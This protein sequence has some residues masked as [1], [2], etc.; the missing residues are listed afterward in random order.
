MSTEAEQPTIH[1]SPLTV[2]PRAQPE[3]YLYVNSKAPHGKEP[4]VP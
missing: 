4:A 1:D 3:S 2:G